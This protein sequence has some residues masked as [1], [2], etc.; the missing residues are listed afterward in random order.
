MINP[1]IFNIMK[2]KAIEKEQIKY[3]VFPKEDVLTDSYD[4]HLRRHLVE[5]ARILG[6]TEKH[7][8]NIYF[9]S[10]EGTHVVSTTIWDVDNDFVTLKCATVLPIRAIRQVSLG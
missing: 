2:A 4:K 7:K 10:V 3:V 5:R 1:L 8:V 6:N 9:D